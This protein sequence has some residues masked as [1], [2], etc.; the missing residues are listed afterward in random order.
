MPG[1]K[2]G[3]TF[4]RT[5][6]HDP[7]QEARRPAQPP[8]ARRR[9]HALVRPPLAA[10]PDRLRRRRLD[11]QAGD[12]DHQ[13]LERHQSLPHASAQ[14]RRER[15]ARRA[16]GRR[17]PDR[18]AGDVAVGNHGE[19]DHDDVP[20]LPRHGDGGAAAQSSARRRGADGRL[21]QDHARPGHG[22]D[23]HGPSGDLH[24]GRTDAA[25]QLDAATTSAPAR[26]SGNT[27]PRSAPATSPTT[28]GTRSR[29]AS[30]ARSAPAW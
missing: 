9:R 6:L 8:L 30:R 15:E 13:H 12:R 10:A 4:Q 3:M 26:T 29:A 5:A 17:L 24:P 25:R 2:P 14:P 7:T 23:Q 28:T 16:A 1:I 20:Q 11:R 22:R 21:R 27:G 19:A 18:A